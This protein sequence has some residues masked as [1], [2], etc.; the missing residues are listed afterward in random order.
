M[1]LLLSFGE[2]ACDGLGVS[3]LARRADMSKSTAFRL[4]G[5]LQ[6]NGAVERT[7]NA[8]RLGARLHELGQQVYTPEHDR[9]RELATPFLIEL[10]ELTH[11]TAHLAVLHGADVLYLNKLYGPHTTPPPSRVGSR[12]PAHCTAGGKVLLAYHH[13]AAS[14]QPSS[15]LARRTPRSI[16]D[17][18]LLRTHLATVREQGVAYD[19]E[20][21][22]P[23]LRCVAAPIFAAPGQVVAALSVTTPSARFETQPHTT[24]VRQ[25]AHRASR[26]LAGQLRRRR[27]VA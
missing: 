5:M 19:D 21:A 1:S 22:R 14:D 13:G 8:Y 25:V 24:A 3:E 26:V 12:A 9:I 11:Q 17:P 23:G 20:E 16:T 4:L 7:G 6:R 2:E 27:V 10:Y 18:V 15:T